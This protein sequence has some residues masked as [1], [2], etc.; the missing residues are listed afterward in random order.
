[1]IKRELEVVA[2]LGHMDYVLATFTLSA[3]LT[4]PKQLQIKQSDEDLVL[5]SQESMALKSK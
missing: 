1:M 4:E 5:E 2:P 3:D